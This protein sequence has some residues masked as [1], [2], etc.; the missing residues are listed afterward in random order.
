MGADGP[1]EAGL[2]LVFERMQ[3]GPEAGV[4]LLW[5]GR[6][7]NSDPFLSDGDGQVFPCR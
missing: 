3:Q 6:M 2:S 4:I 7:E 1:A 5:V